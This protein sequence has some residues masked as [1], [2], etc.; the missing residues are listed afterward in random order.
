MAETTTEI[1]LDS[2]IDR[3]LEGELAYSLLLHGRIGLHWT[4]PSGGRGGRAGLVAGGHNLLG[5][6]L[7]IRNTCQKRW[8]DS[9]ATKMLTLYTMGTADLAGRFQLRWRR[10]CGILLGIARPRHFP[11]P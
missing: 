4:H 8:R 9:C 10:F 3:L 5:V 1:D 11:H 7:A 2:V 6:A